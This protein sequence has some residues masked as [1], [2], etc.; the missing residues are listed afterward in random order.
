MHT[1][2]KLDNKGKIWCKAT[3]VGSKAIGIVA[4]SVMKSIFKLHYS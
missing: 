1:F 2:A 4:L 3:V